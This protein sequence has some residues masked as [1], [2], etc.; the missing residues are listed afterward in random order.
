M[1]SSMVVMLVWCMAFFR[2]FIKYFW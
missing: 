1:T 2:M